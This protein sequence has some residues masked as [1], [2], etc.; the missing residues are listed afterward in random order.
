MDFLAWPPEV[1][2]ALIHAGPGAGSLIEASNA[3][4]QVGIEL[5][6]SVSTYTA[7]VSS[8]AESWDGPSS[9][10]M[11]QAVQPYITWLRNTA[12]QS[13][14]MASSA[15][16]AAT[17]F[18]STLSAVIPPAQVAANRTRLAQLVATNRFGLN[19]PAIATTED[20]YLGMWA[21]NS[22]AFTRYR[23]AAAQ[24]LDLQQFL[25]PPSIA[26]PAGAAAQA[27]ATGAA[28]ATPAASI[29]SIL[30]SIVGTPL[31]FDPNLGWF[32]L[33]N[34]YVNQFISSGFPI[35]LLSYL[36]QTTAAQ[37]LQSVG[38]DVG[39][40]LSEGESALGG[41]GG[42]GEAGTAGLAT[43]AGAMGVAV[44][45]GKLSAPPAVVGLLPASQTPV[46]LASA[47]SPLDATDAGF[48]MLPPLMP[49]PISA[50]SG[51]RKRKQPKLEDLEC[52]TQVKGKVIAPPP[53]AG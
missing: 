6:N 51:W 13:H 7:V 33:G 20:Q 17:A 15:Q 21:N 49:P 37:A 28:A 4:Q 35:N 47:A 22:A 16:A 38:G 18:N 52:G 19:L 10:A 42:L 46:Q 44:S 30:E 32:G 45:V 11:V 2:S 48:P 39:Q 23:A 26:N 36:A 12:Q 25:S 24:A 50:G 9:A 1:T 8:L 31:G 41:L 14:Q 5:E 34:T 53:S 40:G 29:G 27:S 43:P 3:W